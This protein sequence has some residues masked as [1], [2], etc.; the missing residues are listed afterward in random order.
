[1]NDKPRIVTRRSFLTET[2]WGGCLAGLGALTGLSLARS[3]KGRTVW[4]IDPS[5]CVAC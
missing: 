4:Q 3:Q 2:L 1:M 5:K